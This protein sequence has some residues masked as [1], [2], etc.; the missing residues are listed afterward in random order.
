MNSILEVIE[1]NSSNL[2]EY[3]SKKD[4]RKYKFL[5]NCTRELREII[6]HLVAKAKFKYKKTHGHKKIITS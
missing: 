2:N 1:Q 6:P 3:I 5:Q 4:D